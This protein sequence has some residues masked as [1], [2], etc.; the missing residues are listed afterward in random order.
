MATGGFA[1]GGGGTMVP[2]MPRRQTQTA[3]PQMGQSMSPP[4]PPQ[5]ARPATTM[6]PGLVGMGTG[7]PPAGGMHGTAAGGNY[8]IFDANDTEGMNAIGWANPNDP[9]AMDKYRAMKSKWRVK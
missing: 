8:H 1:I 4:G 6:L 3:P 9:K 7:L 2:A 5:Q